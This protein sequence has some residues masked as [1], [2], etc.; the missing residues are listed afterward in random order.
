MPLGMTFR[1]GFFKLNALV[2][3]GGRQKLFAELDCILFG[4]Q[5]PH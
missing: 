2:K 3:E 4:L 1:R 5:I